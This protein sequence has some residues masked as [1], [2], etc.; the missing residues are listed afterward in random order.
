MSEKTRR[1]GNNI[2]YNHA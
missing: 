2:K 1:N